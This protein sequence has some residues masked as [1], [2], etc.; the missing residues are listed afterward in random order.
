VWIPGNYG[1]SIGPGG[2][3]HCPRR[4]CAEPSQSAGNQPEQNM[5]KMRRRG[6]SVAAIVSINFTGRAVT[7]HRRAALFGLTNNR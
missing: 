2:S 1:V 6:Y 3:A 5:A 7:A 4:R